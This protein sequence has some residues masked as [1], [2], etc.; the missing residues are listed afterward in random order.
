MNEAPRH[1]IDT[2]TG[3]ALRGKV[4]QAEVAM[5]FLTAQPDAYGH[6]RQR[7][8]DP[9]QGKGASRKS[10]GSEHIT[11]LLRRRHEWYVVAMIAVRL[12]LA[13]S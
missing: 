6:H 12:R 9:Q 5:A 3:D 8:N 7:S 4:W 13:G 2:R 11:R 1:Q 10:R